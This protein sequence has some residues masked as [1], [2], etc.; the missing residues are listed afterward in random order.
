[1][2]PV[3]TYSPRED[4][5]KLKINIFGITVHLFKIGE[6]RLELRK[7]KNSVWIIWLFLVLEF[8]RGG[9]SNFLDFNWWVWNFRRAETC[10]FFIGWFEVFCAIFGALSSSEFFDAMNVRRD[11]KSP[12]SLGGWIFSSDFLILMLADENISKKQKKSRC[13]FGRQQIFAVSDDLL[14]IRKICEV[15]LKIPLM[16]TNLNSHHS[17]E[18]MNES[19]N[20]WIKARL[21]MQL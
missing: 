20:E 6:T 21:Q 14:K 19:M 9:N 12:E 13:H 10:W 2:I 18:W 11:G 1:M 7:N 5:Y 15:K 16:N 17:I 3:K 4:W 8:F